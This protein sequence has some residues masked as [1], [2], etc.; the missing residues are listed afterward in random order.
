MKK[1][2]WLFLFMAIMILLLALIMFLIFHKNIRITPLIAEKYELQGI[3]VSHYQGDIDWEIIEEQN[4]NFAYIKA[5]EGSSHI[6]ECFEKNWKAA[7]KTGIWIGAYHFFSFDSPGRS[8]AASYID[9]VGSLSGK[10]A[11]VIDVEYYGDKAENPPEREEVIREL[12]EMLIVLE[13]HYRIKPVIYTT[14]K[15]YYD[16]IKD[17]F[18]EYPLW[19]RNVYFTPFINLG[20]NWTFWQYT[21]TAVLEGYKGE[22]KY[23]DRNV[24]NGTREE[25][26]SLIV[27]D[28]TAENDEEE[29]T[30]E[31]FPVLE[32]LFEYEQVENFYENEN[33][34]I[35]TG[36]NERYEKHFED[37]MQKIA[38]KT[39]NYYSVILPADVNGI[40]VKEIGEEAF[41][42]VPM[43][44]IILADSIEK[45]GSG[46]FKNSGLSK[47]QLSENLL[48]IG[49]EAFAGCNLE[50]VEFPA[51]PVAIGNR[52]FADNRELWKV[53]FPNVQSVISENAFEGCD[54]D[55]LICYGEKPEGRENLVMK[56]ADRQGMESMELIIPD[57]PVVNYPDEPLILKPEV[58]S[59]FYGE[60]S[61]FNSDEY[62]FFDMSADAPNFGFWD[63]HWPGCSSWCGCYRFWQEAEASSEL[64]SGNGRYVAENILHQNRDF[65]WAEGADGPGI[66]ESIIYRQS[67]EYGIKNKFQAIRK[68]NMEP[69]LDGF[70]RYSEIC[71]VNGYAKN[72]KTWE[73][74]GR[75]K[76][77]LIKVEGKTYAYLELEDT[78]LPQYYTLPED[79]IKVLNGEMIEF[80]FVIEEVYQ[81]S[82]YE[83]TCL[84]GIVMEFTGRYAH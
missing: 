62:E 38:D 36:I 4:I 46:A 26:K 73:E 76:K 60:D 29:E 1:K 31:E 22:E 33:Y 63:W 84:T 68:G 45:I 40:P 51:Q 49:E 15:A 48:E 3:D 5:T 23:I 70:M 20:N 78:I 19:I 10:L 77:L 39:W 83:D 79:D 59:F 30:E 81:G 80:E 28:K 9:T 2:N 55:F 34:L 24:F 27:V 42:D 67:C 35:I 74:N 54:S 7:Q 61:D 14:Y 13:E 12:K 11:P 17:E 75:I 47:V 8:Q 50:A 16:F 65:A 71:I 64:A 21:D 43:N 72:E 32:Q 25:L 69:E 82:V 52:A 37:Y 18:K 41:C 56:F 6:D 58:K 53:L 44:R 57:E 66:G